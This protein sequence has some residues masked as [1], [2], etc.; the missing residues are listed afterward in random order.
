MPLV[1]AVLTTLII[2]EAQNR[3]R[4]KIGDPSFVF[5]PA[6]GL[7]IFISSFSTVFCSLWV[8]AISDLQAAGPHQHAIVTLDPADTMATAIEAG[9]GISTPS[10]FRTGYLVKVS[11]KIKSYLKDP[12]KVLCDSVPDG[13]IP[14]VHTWAT[15]DGTDMGNVLKSDLQNSIISGKTCFIPGGG[16]WE[17]LVA[18]ISLGFATHVQGSGSTVVG[19]SP[20]PGF[21]PHSH[22]LV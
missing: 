17:D 9:M 8:S 5:P 4:V 19:S 21:P 22:T 15:I 12:T 1:P 20:G 2:T 6:S 11:S 7:K 16:F 3:I 18:S 14:H 10:T 13:S